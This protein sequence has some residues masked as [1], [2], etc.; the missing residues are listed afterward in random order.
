MEERP[1]LSF[2]LAQ[3]RRKLDETAAR[4]AEEIGELRAEIR[5]L[6][7][8]IE[9]DEPAPPP[10]P[11]FAP[12][13][14]PKTPEPEK[15]EKPVVSPFAPPVEPPPEPATDEPPPDAVPEREKGTLELEL[16]RV[17]AVRVGIVLLVTGL[18]LLGNYAYQNWIRE[19]PAG[20]RLGF[21]VLSSFAMSGAGIWCTRKEKLRSFGEVVLAGGMAFFYWCAYAAHHI[22]RLQVIGSPTLGTLA[23]LGAAAAIVA[24]SVLRDARTTAVM[25]LL[26]ASYSTVLQPMT[27]LAAV[28]NVLLAATGVTLVALKRWRGPGFAA[29]L[30]S[31]GAFLYWQLTGVAGGGE[32]IARLVFVAVSWAV[33]AVPT[34]GAMRGLDDRGRAWWIGL[35]NAA[36]FGLFSLVWLIAGRP[37]FWAVA[38]VWGAAWLALGAWG[39]RKA[40][41][42]TYLAQGLAALTLALVLK[43]EGYHLGLGLALESL[44]T[45]AAFRRFRQWPELAFSALSLVGA[46]GWV[47]A[48]ADLPLWSVATVAA[49]LAASSFVLRRS[50]AE[51]S[52]AEQGR[53]T[54]G[55]A[56]VCA[57]LAGFV[58]CERLPADWRPLTAALAAGLLG[59][60]VVKEDTR[61]RMPEVFG[62]ALFFALAAPLLLLLD[63]PA[64]WSL[65]LVAALSAAA[66]WLWERFG[67]PATPRQRE[68]WPVGASLAAWI[69]GLGLTVALGVWL[70]DRPHFQPRFIIEGVAATA[71][72]IAA[73]QLLKA[74][75]LRAAATL[76]LGLPFFELMLRQP[77]DPWLAFL[78][79]LA[80]W[81]VWRVAGRDEAFAEP[82]AAVHA[83]ASRGTAGF[84]WIAAWYWV[85]PGIWSDLLGLSVLAGWWVWRRWLSATPP[86]ELA[87]WGLAATIG[88]LEAM[89]ASTTNGV[90]SGWGVSAVLIA[91]VFLR[92]RGTGARASLAIGLGAVAVPAVWTSKWLLAHHDPAALT[93]L[94]TLLG[95]AWVSIGLWRG[96][97][98]L[99]LGG[100]GLLVISLAKLFIHDVWKFDTFTRVAAFLALGIALVLLGFFYNRFTDLLKR[101]VEEKGEE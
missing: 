15:P 1:Q 83:L 51:G 58:W 45:A 46:T 9:E 43:L 61:R 91:A 99:R 27:T 88:F 72:P 19:M 84:A 7:R 90:P 96:Y 13:P 33:F 80:G 59:W 6:E 17:W 97:S 47:L 18:V 79:T 60:R 49:L 52:L 85:A 71:L 82:G 57:A 56:V 28:S 75:R 68:G 66:A 92:T 69:H 39:R 78:P 63:E 53:N 37:D 32:E 50:G 74:P 34:L 93:I 5:K 3:L 86:V 48:R 23:L 54:A 10:L 94:W 38:A 87:A 76:L 95:F 22:E 62:V 42:Q 11:T 77:S 31:Y 41:G 29:M 14:P 8:L 20:V 67:N 70:I 12:S 26:L 30:G 36:G 35:N 16:G 25:G 55:L 101:L 21:L 89:A 73:W 44:M 24:V 4:H 81:T 100:F 64:D 65:C 40:S 98:V 2:H